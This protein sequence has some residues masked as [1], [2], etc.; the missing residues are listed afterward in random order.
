VKIAVLMG[1]ISDERDVSLASGVQVARALREAGHEVVAF[2]TA[3]GALTREEEVHLLE[4]GVGRLPAAAPGQ[5][6]LASGDTTALTRDPSVGEA[7]V[8]FLALHGGKGED[9]TLQA[10][11]DVVG[12]PYTGS[13]M[14][15]CALAMDKDVSKRL[16]RDAGIPT[17]D[18]LTGDPLPDEVEET[19]GFPVVV[20]AASGGSSLR[21]LLAHDRKEL[22]LAREEARTFRDLVIWERYVPGREFTVAVLGGEALPVGEIIP[23]HEMFDYE[24]KYQPGMAR[25]IFPADL[26]ERQ[27]L[28][29]QDL[30]VDVHRV[31]RLGDFSRVDFVVDPRGRPWCLEAN[32]LP[33]MTA[34]SLVPKAAQ[35]AGISFPELCDRIATLALT[36]AGGGG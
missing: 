29:L 33:G 34:N 36:R 21:L 19:L 15:G 2:D 26:R 11:L 13:G 4:S 1:G 16:M 25:E 5:D 14:L 32:G 28:R 27:A 31:L 6:L 18:W 20:K 23:D 22:D 17:P 24:C 3:R 7:D 30:A 8:F 9:G 10:L 35:A 12:R